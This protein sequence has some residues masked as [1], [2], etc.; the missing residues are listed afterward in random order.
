MAYFLVN[1]LIS[2]FIITL[3]HQQGDIF[4]SVLYSHPVPHI[5]CVLGIFLVITIR[6]GHINDWVF[7]VTLTILDVVMSCDTGFDIFHQEIFWFRVQV[8]HERV[9]LKTPYV[10]LVVHHCCD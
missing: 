5:I 6:L 4:H 9:T 3:L 8:P 10:E 1:L 7:V 2:T